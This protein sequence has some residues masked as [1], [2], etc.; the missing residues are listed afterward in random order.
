M[1]YSI[2]LLLTVTL[3]AGCSGKSGAPGGSGTPVT[4]SGDFSMKLSFE[5]APPKQGSETFTVTLTDASGNP[6]KGATVTIDTTMPDMQMS[7]PSLHLQ[8]NDDGSYSG[9]ANLAYQTKWV[10]TAR[11]ARQEKR[12][13][14]EFVENI[15]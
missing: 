4:S 3:L 6:V 7:G 12:G 10:F 9:V 11:A 14:A 1:R 8:D 13:S 15:K 5:P 2:I